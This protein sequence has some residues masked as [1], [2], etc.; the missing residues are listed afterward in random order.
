MERLARQRRA[1]FAWQHHCWMFAFV[2]QFGLIDAELPTPL[3]DL[4]LWWFG[5]EPCWPDL[6]VTWPRERALVER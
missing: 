3:M 5:R 6:H 2:Q 1:G 4:C